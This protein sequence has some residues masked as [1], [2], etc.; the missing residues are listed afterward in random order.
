MKTRE[1]VKM[2]FIFKLLA[3]L[4]IASFVWSVICNTAMNIYLMAHGI[5]PIEYRK[6]MSRMKDLRFIPVEMENKRG[7]YKITNRW[8]GRG[9]FGLILDNNGQDESICVTEK[10]WETYKTG[11]EIIVEMHIVR[12]EDTKE[13]MEDYCNYRVLGHADGNLACGMINSNI[14]TDKIVQN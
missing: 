4:F 10:E 6:S 3:I 5:D 2:A 13:L 12:N 11:E 9:Q 1:V 7:K 8:H 14:A